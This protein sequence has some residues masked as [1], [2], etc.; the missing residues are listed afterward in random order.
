[1][2]I[3]AAAW[4]VT[5]LF[6]LQKLVSNKRFVCLQWA[7]V[8]TDRQTD[9]QTDCDSGTDFRKNYDSLAY[10]AL[11]KNEPISQVHTLR[12]NQWAVSWEPQREWKKHTQTHTWSGGIVHLVWAAACPQTRWVVTMWV[13]VADAVT[14][15]QSSGWGVLSGDFLLLSER[16][17]LDPLQSSADRTSWDWVH[18]EPAGHPPPH[19]HPD[20][21][22]RYQPYF[23]KDKKS[24][25]LTVSDRNAPSW[26]QT[27]RRKIISL[28]RKR[29]RGG[30]R[31]FVCITLQVDLQTESKV[32]QAWRHGHMCLVHYDLHFSD[33]DVHQ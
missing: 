3:S 14:R 6:P 30:W 20:F 24:L 5:G 11:F 17:M 10:W 26:N 4:G 21:S 18:V 25:I 27:K 28:D 22:N 12:G 9:R 15:F 33:A 29:T 31:Q 23:H 19:P 32:S 8:Q 1:M 16:E 7:A 13:L 2:T